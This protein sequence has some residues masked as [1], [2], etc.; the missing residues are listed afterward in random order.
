VLSPNEPDN[1]GFFSIYRELIGQQIISPNP[2]LKITGVPYSDIFNN[3]SEYFPFR[4]LQAIV[5]SNGMCS[6][7]TREEALI[8]GLSEICERFVLKALYLSPFC[9]PDI[10]IKWFEGHDIYNKIILLNEVEK[11]H[12]EIKDCSMNQSLPVIGVLVKSGADKY[13]FHLGADP[14]PVTALE[15]GFTEMYQGG[16]INFLSVSELLKN[17]PYNLKT[18]FWKRNFS[19]TISSY[20]GHWPGKI[21]NNDPS[22]SFTGFSHPVSVSDDDDLQYL[23]NL[24]KDL[25]RKIFIR[26]NSFLGQPSYHVYIP[27]MSEITNVPDDS[28]LKVFLDFDEH[29]PVISNLKDSDV[30]ERAKMAEAVKSY[31]TLSPNKEFRLHDYFNYFRKHPLASLTTMQ[32][33]SLIELSLIEDKISDCFE[34]GEIESSPLLKR[35]LEIDPHMA[36]SEVLKKSNIPECFDCNYCIFRN[37]CN[38]PYLDRI[39]NVLREKMKLFY[40]ENQ[41][42]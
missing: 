1:R 28:F 30:A 34:V 42:S 38:F 23:Y 5:G 9:P 16:S 37:E 6:G 14:S 26:D 3:K 15:R 11:Y 22:Y 12:V 32:F 21:L 36:A 13:A 18:D 7:N 4:A 27:G 29:I 10:P 39:W 31:S 17:Q 2:D 20:S 8:Q 33:L 41:V 35:M 40:N 25:G 24:I 19:M